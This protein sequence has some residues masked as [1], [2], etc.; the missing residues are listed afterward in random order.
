MTL[1]R[2]GGSGLAA[3]FAKCTS[4]FRSRWSRSSS[5]NSWS[6]CAK[7]NNDRNRSGIVRANAPPPLT[8]NS[9]RFSSPRVHLRYIDRKTSSRQ[10]GLMRGAVGWEGA[11]PSRAICVRSSKVG[12]GS[13][14]PR[15]CA[16]HRYHCTSG[17]LRMVT[18]SVPSAPKY[19]D[20]LMI[21]LLQCYPPPPQGLFVPAEHRLAAAL[22][23]VCLTGL[24]VSL[25]VKLSRSRSWSLER[26]QPNAAGAP[27][28][29]RAKSPNHRGYTPP[30]PAHTPTRDS[31]VMSGVT[32]N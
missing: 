4:V 14:P 27:A 28:R 8:A 7:R 3:S 22:C 25:A 6:A 29:A 23:L 30:C 5:S 12:R 18:W 16:W 15:A 31:T 32:Q 10:S 20:Q 19:R 17:S 26:R 1:W 2:S 9:G 11:H 24:L 13:R 21:M